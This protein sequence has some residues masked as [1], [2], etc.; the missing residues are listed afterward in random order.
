MV[1]DVWHGEATRSEVPYHK[2]LGYC[3][4]RLVDAARRRDYAGMQE[5]FDM[6]KAGRQ[7]AL[8]EPRLSAYDA[9]LCLSM[10]TVAHSR[11]S[12]MEYG[13]VYE[14][15]RAGL[16]RMDRRDVRR[17]SKGYPHQNGSEARWSLLRVLAMALGQDPDADL[18]QALIPVADMPGMLRRLATNALD[19]ARRDFKQGR[20]YVVSL[21]W[22]AVS[23]SCAMER[24]GLDTAELVDW[25][26]DLHAMLDGSRPFSAEVGYFMTLQ[27]ENGC[28]LMFWQMEYG[29]LWAAYL[30]G[31]RGLLTEEA[32]WRA[33]EHLCGEQL[34]EAE[35]MHDYR[36]YLKVMQQ[37]MVQAVRAA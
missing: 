23:V 10:A 2:A 11:A 21:L 4:N 13:P 33:Y 17:Q 32:A 19:L 20:V 37:R 18:T 26:N 36:E 15:A 27:G 34:R 6:L 7:Y 8:D 3:A 31:E 12:R 1:L 24:A 35:K 25:M 5:W 16:A 30:R 29:K 28:G 14:L 9:A 22:A